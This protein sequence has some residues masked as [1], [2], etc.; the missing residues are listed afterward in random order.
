MIDC[1]IKLNIDY[2]SRDLIRKFE[3]KQKVLESQQCYR[4]NNELFVAMFRHHH[5]RGKHGIN[6]MYFLL[7]ACLLGLREQQLELG[8]PSIPIFCN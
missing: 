2:F 5:F 1:N 8:S 7:P 6:S 3:T 4:W